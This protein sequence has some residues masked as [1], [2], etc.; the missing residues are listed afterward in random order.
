MP[1][2]RKRPGRPG[3]GDPRRGGTV[4]AFNA[5][6]MRGDFAGGSQAVFTFHGDKPLTLSR[7]LAQAEAGRTSGD[8]AKSGPYIGPGS[9]PSGSYLNAVERMLQQAPEN[10]AD[11]SAGL[12]PG[13]GP[14]ISRLPAVAFQPQSAKP[15]AIWGTPSACLSIAT[16]LSY[17]AVTQWLDVGSYFVPANRTLII[18]DVWLRFSNPYFAQFIT[19]E[20]YV[21][22]VASGLPIRIQADVIDPIAVRLAALGPCTV[23]L[24]AIRDFETDWATEL[25]FGITGWEVYD[26]WPRNERLLF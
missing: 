23:T 18:T 19:A 1:L 15:V 7:L 25:E 10:G 3:S 26:E 24:R 6:S 5:R 22:G 16:Q 20:I 2:P 17:G 8:A 13:L 12:V 21:D 4:P 14:A 9:G 11:V